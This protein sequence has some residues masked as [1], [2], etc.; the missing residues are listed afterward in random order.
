MSLI[1]E[2]SCQADLHDRSVSCDEF[3]V[4]II[5]PKLPNVLSDR[6]AV[7][8]SEGAGELDRMSIYLR[9]DIGQ[10][11]TLSKALSHQFRSSPDP[12]RWYLA[13]DHG[14]TAVRFCEQF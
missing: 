4:S 10:R 11:E 7:I 13:G 3:S 5:D 8:P 12:D 2:P 1:T 14:G 9:S 6:I